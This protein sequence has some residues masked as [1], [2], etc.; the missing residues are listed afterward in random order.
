MKREDLIAR[1]IDIYG[2]EGTSDNIY[3]FFAPGR[4]N[5]I[6]EHTDY[7]GGHVFPCALTLGT[8][9]AV[10]PR[11]DQTIRFAS[12]NVKHGEI[13]STSL[14]DLSWKKQDGWTNYPKGVIDCF[15]K[16]GNCLDHGFDVLYYGDIP[17]GAGLSSSASIEVVTGL[18]IKT[19]YHFDT[20]NMID[21][22]VLAQR[23]ESSYVGVRCGIMDQFASAMGKK[24]TAIFLSTDNMKYEYVPLKLDGLHLVV[25]NSKIHHQ[26]G[27]SEYNKRRDE[28]EK[29]L[30]KLQVVANVNSLCDL[31]TDTFESCKDVIMDPVLT[32][33]ARHAVYENARTIR[34]V[35]A[36]R[37]NNLKRFGQLLN[38]SHVSLRDDYEVSCPEIDYL[39]ELAWNEP[40]VLGSRMT[41]GGFGGCTISLVEDGEVEQFKEVLS[42]KYKARYNLVPD[43]YV[44][45][46]GDGARQL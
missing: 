18:L 29:A 12:L 13:R 39:V 4:V 5:L 33:R 9:A 45:E 23:A 6:G 1:F 7:N 44:V 20:I 38:E 41:G 16:R 31:S 36:L 17:S 14:C 43:F 22:A 15:L 34:A 3:V 2:N 42:S 40:G 46:T 32:K 26:L 19:L 11:T 24:D 25:T 10:R 8:Y 35:N 21:I 30:K 27:S 28:C 37:V